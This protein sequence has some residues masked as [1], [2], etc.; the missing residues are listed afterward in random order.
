METRLLTRYRI[1]KLVFEPAGNDHG[2]MWTYKHL[3][4]E[5]NHEFDSEKE[6]LLWVHENPEIMIRCREFVILPVY[7]LV[8]A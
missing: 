8:L 4:G 7:H 6:A 5:Q 2:A 1:F 3:H